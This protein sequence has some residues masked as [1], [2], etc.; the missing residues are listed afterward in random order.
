MKNLILFIGCLIFI[1]ACQPT[2]R[3]NGPVQVYFGGDILTMEGDAPVYV[4]AL[5]VKEGKIIFVGSKA[6][7]QRQAGSQAQTIDL[8]GKM[9]MPS[10]IDGHSHFTA[11]FLE[12]GQANCAAPPV[13]QVKNPQDVVQSLLTHKKDKQL[14]DKALIIGFGYDD[15]QMPENQSVNRDIL[16]QAFPENPVV[17]LHVSLHGVVL[18]SKAMALYGISASTPTPAGGVIVRKPGTQEPYGLIMETAAAPIMASLT[19]MEPQQ[20]LKQLQ[21]AQQMYAA[22]GITTAQDGATHWKEIQMLRKA[23]QANA[24]MLDIV[25]YAIFMEAD[26]VYRY[27]K[28]EDF[29]N[30]NRRLKIGGI[31]FVLDGSPQ[32]RTALF[33]TTYQNGGPSGE[34]DWKG[35]PI[36]P[37]NIFNQLLQK[38]YDK[39]LQCLIHA[40][41]DGAIDMALI[42]DSV[43]NKGKFDKDRRTI[44]IHAQFIRKDQI[45]AFVKQKLIGSFF[46]AHTFFFAAAHLKNRGEAQTMSI[47]PLKRALAAGVKLTNHTDYPVTPLNQLFLMWT[48]VNRVSREG[49]TI[50]NDERISPYQALQAITIFG[51][52]QYFEEASKGSLKA[53][54]LADLVILDKNPLKVA[55]EAIKDIK[56]LETIKEGKTIYKR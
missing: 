55:P 8:K 47:S 25:S 54:K 5:V 22:A 50:G 10:F 15:T 31:K 51:A 43:A 18:N 16:D 36:I 45:Q 35:K 6:D 30:Y 48:A 29:G 13:G 2:A 21:L 42:A 23:A 52:Y 34:K 56:V 20:A 32:A 41:G 17:V 4:E 27:L 28:P 12:A 7:A 3:Q 14:D 26:S 37:Q 11:A 38:A 24:L 40:N 46:T 53:G 39:N 44:V 49:K 19:K 9:L 33:T 1:G